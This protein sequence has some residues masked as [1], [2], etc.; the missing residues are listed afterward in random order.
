[1]FR[2]NASRCPGSAISP[3]FMSLNK[4]TKRPSPFSSVLPHPIRGPFFR[5][6]ASPR[7][8]VPFFAASVTGTRCD[9]H[10]DGW[11]A[12]RFSLVS[13]A[14]GG[15]KQSAT[16]FSDDDVWSDHLIKPK[17]RRTA[18][19]GSPVR[20]GSTSASIGT[21]KKRRSSGL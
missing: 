11:A 8:A 2:Q 1:C 4:C 5:N 14:G 3:C 18:S 20:G 19:N 12:D 16:R 6:S 13:Q 17:A 21:H 15:T 7:S 9:L 10:R